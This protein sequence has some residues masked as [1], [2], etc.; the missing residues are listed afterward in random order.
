MM[1]EMFCQNLPWQNGGKGDY[2]HYQIFDGTD[3]T[4]LVCGKNTSLGLRFW[5]FDNSQYLKNKGTVADLYSYT[6]DPFYENAPDTSGWQEFKSNQ[7]GIKLIHPQPFS[8]VETFDLQTKEPVIFVYCNS[9]RLYRIM[10]AHGNFSLEAKNHRWSIKD[11]TFGYRID[12]ENINRSAYLEGAA[13]KAIYVVHSDPHYGENNQLITSE[14][15][16]ILVYFFKGF[17][18]PIILDEIAEDD[19]GCTLVD[20]NLLML[21]S[22]IKNK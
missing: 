10:R 14:A 16:S 2:L 20:N 6:L 9:T 12:G 21:I 17:S 18:A 5:T 1:S 3:S 15:P 22:T 19:V 8:I 4:G 7:L 13:W 11:S